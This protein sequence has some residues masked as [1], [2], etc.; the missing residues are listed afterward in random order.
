LTD[1]IHGGA[2][3]LTTLAAATGASTACGSCRRLLGELL[4]TPTGAG[5]VN[6]WRTLLAAAG[7]ALI[8]LT[9]YLAAEP[10]PFSTTVQSSWR[11][12]DL[13]WR[14]PVAKQTTGFALVGASAA[15]LVLS[16]RKRWR[17]FQVGDYGW[18][19]TAHG[20][21]GVITVLGFLVHTGLRL[22]SN[23]TFALAT[24]FLAL[25]FAGA[26][27][28]V[29]AA[30]ESHAND[31]VAAFVRRWRSRLVHLHIWLFWPAPALVVFH[32]ISIY[33]F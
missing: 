7:L 18:W 25:N 6:G 15:A 21:V 12:V 27:A 1:A 20:A 32:V 13:L 19:R 17:R 33:Y 2:T 29:A 14:D 9:G 4:G 11:S 5:A 10:L 23:L 30:L 31:L 3:D 26:L 8:L 16:L 22:G 24:V 28:G